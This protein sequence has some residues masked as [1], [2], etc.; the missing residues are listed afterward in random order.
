MFA[1]VTSELSANGKMTL[2]PFQ[3]KQLQELHY[4]QQLA[5][6]HH[7]Q[8]S[9][10]L[11][12]A[13]QAQG[14]LKDEQLQQLQ[15]LQRDQVQPPIS[16]DQQGVLLCDTPPCEPLPASVHSKES[17]FDVSVFFNT[18][19][20]DDTTKTDD[21]STRTTSL[22]ISGP[23]SPTFSNAS[24]TSPLSIPSLP[25]PTDVH[26]FVDVEL[27]QDMPDPMKMKLEEMEVLEY[28]KQKARRSS[29][30]YRHV[31]HSIAAICNHHCSMVLQND[32]LKASL[33][34][35]IRKVKQI[36]DAL[37]DP[38]KRKYVHKT[39]LIAFLCCSPGCAQTVFLPCPNN[40]DEELSLRILRYT[41]IT[42]HQV[43]L[44]CYECWTS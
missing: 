15:Q 27:L 12:K 25:S 20:G 26:D 9:G 23:S 30:T 43:P 39:D 16:P 1:S 32:R 21:P 36:A 31:K 42:G 44:R 37:A 22:S 33:E 19:N 10:A 41:R 35:V 7:E 14:V 3:V 17:E 40:F 6:W 24:T 34:I 8:S 13:A 2:T 28:F 29:F 18:E 5:N 11:Q 38:S 4:L